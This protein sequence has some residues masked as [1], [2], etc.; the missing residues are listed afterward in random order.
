LIVLVRVLFA[1]PGMESL[2]LAVLSAVA[3]LTMTLGNVMALWQTN[4]RRMLAY[5]SVAHS[6]YLLIGLV[7]ALH[8]SD[9]AAAGL[10]ATLFYTA[11]YALASAGSFAA[12]AYL[13]RGAREVETLDDLAGIGRTRP[14]VAALLAIFMFSLAGIPPLVGFWGKLAIFTGPLDVYLASLPHAGAATTEAAQSLGQ[15]YLAIAVIGVLNAAVAA[16]YYLRIV[17]TMYFRPAIDDA[18]PQGGLGALAAATLC[19]LAVIA[20]G[21]FPGVGLKFAQSAGRMTLKQSPSI[22]PT[23]SHELAARANSQR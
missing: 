15:W 11:V 5:S 17:A 2:A 12:L 22:E 1:M 9:H 13:V 10:A 18:E 20:G 23:R 21:I 16:A 7:T 4:V 14:G 19:G 3:L 8:R 6:G